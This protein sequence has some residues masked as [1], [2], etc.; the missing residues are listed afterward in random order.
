[1]DPSAE[2]HPVVDLNLVVG[3]LAVDPSAADHLVVD[4][5]LAADLLVVDHLVVDLSLVVGHLAE[6]QLLAVD[7]GAFLQGRRS[8]VASTA[9][10]GR[11]ASG[12]DSASQFRRDQRHR[13]WWTAVH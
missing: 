4:R 13:D 11:V 1:M 7:A 12:K 6:D 3:L 2:D 8:T 9:L 5:L 10:A